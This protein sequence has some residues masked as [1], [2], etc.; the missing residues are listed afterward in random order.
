MLSSACQKQWG[1]ENVQ[2]TSVKDSQENLSIQN[3]ISGD[4][5]FGND[6]EVGPLSDDN[7]RGENCF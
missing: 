4:T 2:I 7:K 5:P 1:Q 6:D 3:E